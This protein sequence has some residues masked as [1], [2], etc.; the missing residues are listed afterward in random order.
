[1]G[2]KA[3]IFPRWC[4]GF[5][6]MLAAGLMLAWTWRTWPDPLVDFGRE[7]Y[8]PWQITMGRVLYRD[9]AYFNGPLSPY[10]NALWMRLLGVSLTTLIVAN[11]TVL[12]AVLALLYALLDAAASRVAALLGALLFVTLFAFGRL[13]TIGNY[14]FVCPYSHEITHGVALS[15]G[16]LAC[17]HLPQTLRTRNIAGSALLMGLVFLTKAEVALACFIAV[18]GGFALRMAGQNSLLRRKLTTVLFGGAVAPGV[19]SFALLSVRMPISTALRG[20][21][22][23]F[24]WALASKV[25]SLPF[26]RAGLG[27]DNL[28]ANLVQMGVGA[29]LLV[30]AALVATGAGFFAPRIT[31]ANHSKPAALL[32]FAAAA[33]VGILTVHSPYWF[34]SVPKALPLATAFFVVVW[35]LAFHREPRLTERSRVLALRVAFSLFA[36]S[37]L[38]KMIFNVRLYH[39]GFALAMP[40]ML[41]LLAAFTS[42]GPRFLAARGA[43]GGVVCAIGFALACI[44]AFT[45][46][47]AMSPLLKSERYRVGTGSDTFLADDRGA[48]VQLALHWIDRTMPA[49]ATLAVLPEGAMINYLARRSN[50]TPYVNL[51]PPEVIIFGEGRVL[52]EFKSRPPDF[53][54]LCHKD[55]TEYGLPLFGH[56][57]GQ[58]LAAWVHENYDELVL[59]GDRPLEDPQRFGMLL[60]RRRNAG[61]F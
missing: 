12:A 54:L 45:Y 35:F 10:V 55:T 13:V 52:R 53:V 60:L 59:I 1:M 33:A 36:L 47:S 5:I 58:S 29:A 19:L 18:A 44:M 15:L 38:A 39:Y 3:W 14:N 41:L 7:L 21:L 42:W 49:G 26:Y 24:Y 30:A 57:Y 2:R 32:G 25:S 61:A 34:V 28:P 20:V 40:A 16:A 51:M 27:L 37:L 8:V 22:G 31:S 43:D 9:I 6:I 4:D 50:S 11:L 56:D 17:L 23:S 46:L 48:A